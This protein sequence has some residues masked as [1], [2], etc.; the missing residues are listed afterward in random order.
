MKLLAGPMK[1]LTLL[2]FGVSHH[3][4]RHVETT[5]AFK[6]DTHLALLVQDDSTFFAE[7]HC[8][9]CVTDFADAPERPLYIRHL[10]DS[11]DVC[12]FPSGTRP[13]PKPEAHLTLVWKLRIVG[14]DEVLAKLAASARLQLVVRGILLCCYVIAGP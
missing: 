12:A 14:R 4:S 8:E 6:R 10:K 13:R 7:L 3:E 1:T 9:P 2:V 11:L 5:A